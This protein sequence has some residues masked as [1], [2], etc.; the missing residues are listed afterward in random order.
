MLEKILKYA[1]GLT[2]ALTGI[3]LVRLLMIQS[4]MEEYLGTVYGVGLFIVAAVILG[5]GMFFL[6]GKVIDISAGFVDKIEDSLQKI[7]LYELLIGAT[8]LYRLI[9]A[10]LFLFRCKN[11]LL[12]FRYPS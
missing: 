9:I 7:T 11:Q 4:N 12:E 5:I 2:G 8:G 10:N 1:F 6:G 3:S